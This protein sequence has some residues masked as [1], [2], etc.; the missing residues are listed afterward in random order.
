MCLISLHRR[1]HMHTQIP[2]CRLC[3][4]F[5][6]FTVY[7]WGL[8]LIC[9][10]RLENISTAPFPGLSNT[11]CVSVNGCVKEEEEK[12]EESEACRCLIMFEARKILLN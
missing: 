12:A 8:G 5:K 7:P 3:W 10:D 4:R 6:P 11:Q 1:T 9:I 2:L